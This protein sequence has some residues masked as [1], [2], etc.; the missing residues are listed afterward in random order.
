MAEEQ[1]GGGGGRAGT[2][3]WRRLVSGSR[4][5][6]IGGII[7]MLVGFAVALG[8]VNDLVMERQDMREVARNSIAG[9]WGPGQWVA[10]PYLIVPQQVDP[11]PSLSGDPGRAYRVLLPETLQADVTVNTEIRRR[12]L[13]DVPVY[14]LQLKLHGEFSPLELRKALAGS[15]LTAPVLALQLADP[16][17]II[18]EPLAF[19]QGETM[20]VTPDVMDWVAAG[21]GRDV[22]VASLPLLGGRMAGS[23][24]TLSLSLRGTGDFLMSPTGQSSNVTMAASW[25]HPSFMGSRTADSHDISDDGFLARW[26]LGGFGRAYPYAW[27]YQLEG[28]TGSV[29][30]GAGDQAGRH[31]Q[32]IRDSAFG[33]ALVQPVDPY[34]MT[35]RTLKY[36]MLFALYTFGV[37]LLLEMAFGVPLHWLHYLLTGASVATFFLLLLSL[38]EVIGFEA[39]YWLGTGAVV[40]QVG[41][42]ARSAIRNRRLSIYF[43][44]VLVILYGSL[45]GL[46]HLEERA[47]LLGSVGLFVV[48]GAA[49]ALARRLGRRKK[50]DAAA[51]EGFG[52]A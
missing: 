32:S 49:M 52:V 15:D 36:G 40:T 2:G 27:T 41:L 6:R 39:G 26:R 5:G 21:L 31:I 22:I 34:R 33:V 30:N 45:F 19:W 44:A 9:L 24:F 12:G 48:I 17:T 16:A 4:A 8:S 46:L 10:G 1:P 43:S 28:E 18:G 23:D 29:E 13:F 35:A 7:A 3:R 38:S 14:E 37:F 11:L 47:L 50:A 51:M 25:P 20:A 42:F